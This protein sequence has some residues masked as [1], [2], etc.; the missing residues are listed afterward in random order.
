MWAT[1]KN[2]RIS[3]LIFCN[4][5]FLKYEM[6]NIIEIGKC[7]YDNIESKD[8]YAQFQAKLSVDKTIS[9]KS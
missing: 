4:K 5:I 2:A 3:L 8:T 1:E 7:T 9:N 6:F